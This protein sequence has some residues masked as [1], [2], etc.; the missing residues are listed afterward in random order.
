MS[1][2]LFQGV[3]HQ[4]KDAIDRVIGVIDENGVIIACSELVRVGE[5]KQ[6]IRDELSY[7]SELIVSDGFTYRPINV[8][9]KG[10]YTVFVEGEDKT[11]DKMSKIL[12]ISLGNIKN[13]YDEKYDKGS[14]IKNIIL[15]NM[16]NLMI[17]CL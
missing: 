9:M 13:L 1:N 17:Y 5:I 16:K 10:E 12:T 14:F 8:G 6:G 3:I 7:S 4:M 15:D 2:R 11:A